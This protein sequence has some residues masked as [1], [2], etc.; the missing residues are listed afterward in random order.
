VPPEAFVSGEI[1]AESIIDGGIVKHHAD[2]ANRV[3]GKFFYD[4]ARGWVGLEGSQYRR[5][6]EL[7]EAM[8][9]RREF[10]PH[11]SSSFLED[12]IFLWLKGKHFKE[13]DVT[14]VEHIVRAGS[15]MIYDLEVWLPIPTLSTTVP[16]AVGNVE[17]RPIS[18]DLIDRW[19]SNAKDREDADRYFTEI[20]RKFQGLAA[21][22]MRVVAEPV[23]AREIAFE[24]AEKST[25]AL[26]LFSP[27][28][29]HPYGRSYWEPLG[30]LDPAGFY[31]FL[32][33]DGNLR[34][35]QSWM[36][37][38]RIGH[39]AL[40]EQKVITLFSMGLS[41][42]DSLLRNEQPVND[43]PIFPQGD[44]LKIP[45]SSGCFSPVSSSSPGLWDLWAAP[46]LAL[47]KELWE[48]PLLA[49]SIAPSGSIGHVL[50]FRG[51]G[52]A[53]GFPAPYTARYA[54]ADPPCASP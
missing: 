48:T 24:E 19:Q 22:T 4:K 5:L 21:A 14:A 45:L 46:L 26:R 30:F 37:P 50:L 28:I 11:L 34:F 33:Q 43:H 39:P 10:S 9:R 20:R 3:T 6:V 47:S 35:R 52:A 2:V 44:H 25:A 12:Q 27:E 7:A 41:K 18:S 15:G 16:F 36:S 8:Q 54:S 42:V 31:V 40:D 13:A 29:L 51:W 1:P 32:T 17:F 53:P 23:R 49:F 38:D